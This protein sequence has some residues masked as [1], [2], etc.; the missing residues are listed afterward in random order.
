L[1]VDPLLKS[2]W[3][4]VNIRICALKYNIKYEIMK[5]VVHSKWKTKYIAKYKKNLTN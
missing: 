4:K 1:R 3:F 5:V 2:V